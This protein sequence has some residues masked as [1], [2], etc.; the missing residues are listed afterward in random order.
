MFSPPQSTQA[1]SKV[2]PLNN[3]NPIECQQ[4]LA[5]GNDMFPTV[6]TG[7]TGCPYYEKLLPTFEEAC[8]QMPDRDCYSFNYTSEINPGE[9]NCALNTRTVSNCLG[10]IPFFSPLMSQYMVAGGSPTLGN[11]TLGPM[12]LGGG[13]GAN[14]T[15]EE[16][17]AFINEL[18]ANELPEINF[19]RL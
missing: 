12:N 13:I 19:P 4:T 16:V 3:L 14:S 11:Q 17:K 18:D 1:S 6:I 2:I 15:V 9:L 7:F 5:S 10:Y 8:E